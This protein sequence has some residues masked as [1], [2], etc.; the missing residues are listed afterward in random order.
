MFRERITRH[1]Q[2]L[3]PSFKRIADF[4]LTSHQRV[5]FMSAS[6]LAR[7]LGVDVATVTRFSQQLGY[8]GYIE[9]IREIQEEVLDEMRKA[10]APVTDRLEAA[11]SPFARTLWRDWANLEKTIQ[12]LLMDQ[13]DMAIAAIRSA[14]RIYLVSEGVGAGLARAGA[15]YLSMAKHDVVALDQGPFDLALALKDLGPEDLVIGIGFTNYASLTAR[16]MQ[17]GRKVGARTIGIIA[18]ADCP[19]AAPAELLFACSATE[20]GYLPSLT[21]VGA[22]L[23]ALIYTYLMED[24][25]KYQQETAR[26][27]EAYTDITEGTSRSEDSEAEELVGR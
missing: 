17:L 26:F 12:N 10:R 16:A 2:S 7:H 13:A 6:R 27:E 9:L 22:I 5:A 21:V 15:S 20:E 1:Y 14:R 11:P 25:E 19:V 24:G 4:I 8:E 3:S 18:Q 23:F